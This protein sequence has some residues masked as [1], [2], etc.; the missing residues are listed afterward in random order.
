MA[1]AFHYALKEYGNLINNDQQNV[2]TLDYLNEM[3]TNKPKEVTFQCH[4]N[5]KTKTKTA[6]DFLNEIQDTKHLAWFE[7][8]CKAKNIENRW[9]K[10]R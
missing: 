6:Q 8:L 3:F 4:L 2:S 5:G 10:D 7:S 1:D 9:P